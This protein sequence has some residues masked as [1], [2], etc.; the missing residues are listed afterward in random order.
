MRF[1]LDRLA[2]PGTLRSLAV[3]VFALKGIVPDEAMLQN[4][5][6]LGILGLGA[7]SALMPE[8]KTP[9]PKPPRRKAATQKAAAA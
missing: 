6:N 8:Y 9:K 1:L 3:I 5:V 2:E 7:V 4:L